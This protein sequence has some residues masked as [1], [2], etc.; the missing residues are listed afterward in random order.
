MLFERFV[1]F[2]EG[3]KFRHLCD[4]HSILYEVKDEL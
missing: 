1:S 3:L 2:I 4:T